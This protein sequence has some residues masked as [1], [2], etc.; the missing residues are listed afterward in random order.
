MR[1][2][3]L[4][5]LL[6]SPLYANPAVDWADRVQSDPCQLM[7]KK[8]LAKVIVMMD[9]PPAGWLFKFLPAGRGI[10]PYGGAAAD[11]R[12]YPIGTV[13]YVPPPIDGVRVVTMHARSKIG[14]SLFL[15]EVTEQGSI[16]GVVPL[17][18]VSAEKIRR[19]LS[20]FGQAID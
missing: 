8:D 20:M 19:I 18:V 3:I 13:F 6:A 1:K 4:C 16:G 2:V 9:E 12:L 15:P 11:A 14:R 7:I 17:G 5:I 10:I